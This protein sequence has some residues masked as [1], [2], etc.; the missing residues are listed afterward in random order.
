[1]GLFSSITGL[2][3]SGGA[4]DM[5]AGIAPPDPETM[6]LVLEDYVQQGILTPED[7]K[8][9]MQDPS[10][11][12][13]IISDPKF[14]EAQM[15]A[16]AGLQDIAEQG[17][18]TATDK[19]R[20]N[21]IA[22]SEGV[23][24]RGAREA[25]L[26][27]AAERGVSGSG[28]E[29]MAQLKSQQESAGRQSDRDTE[30]AAEAERRA[31]EALVNSGN[32][33]GNIRGQDFSEASRIAQAKDEINRFNTNTLNNFNLYNVGNRNE[34]QAKNLAAKQA[35]ADANV[36]L[37]NTAQQYNKNL[38]Q[39]DFENKM[40]LAGAKEGAY[41]TDEAQKLGS[42]SGIESGAADIISGGYGALRKIKKPTDEDM[43]A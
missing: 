41:K 19:A 25:I 16:L 20:L 39:K 9:V 27:N 22:K 6:K 29:L 1:M 32:M 11:F 33:A 23:R 38:Y 35:I 26:Q 43:Y 18:L 30:V 24:E 40:K 31:L 8:A 42:I 21:D 28:L 10:A 7:A 2:L 14:K 12:E 13:S 37:H 5:Y 34:A 4:Q 15:K 3:D 36:G 17:G